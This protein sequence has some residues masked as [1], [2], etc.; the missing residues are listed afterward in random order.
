M[1]KNR[2]K[3]RIVNKTGG[4]KEERGGRKKEKI[5]VLLCD[6]DVSVVVESRMQ[7]SVGKKKKKRKSSMIYRR[8]SI[9]NER[10]LSNI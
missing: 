8:F 10:D 7:W 6:T 2:N 9:P 3:E 5:A 4:K 1:K